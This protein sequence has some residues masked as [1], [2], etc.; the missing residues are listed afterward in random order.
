MIEVIRP[1]DSAQP[2]ARRR[3][4]PPALPDPPW[5]PRLVAAAID[6]LD[7]VCRKAA[8]LE[9]RFAGELC[10][11]HSNFR[12]S[13]R[14]LV[15]YLALRDHDIR[16]LQDRLA[17]LG[18]SSLGRTE[19]HVIASID[20]VARILRQLSGCA[21]T[22]API[23]PLPIAFAAGEALLAAHTAAAL[24]PRRPECGAHI[25]VTMPR[26][27]ADDYELVRQ[28][29]AGGMDCM[30]INCAH[31]DREAWSRMVANLRRAMKEL[32]RDC[33]LLMDLSGPKL[34]TGPIDPTSQT[35][36]WK[37]VRN[38]GG[39]VTTPA[40]VW[41][42]AAENPQR[43]PAPADAYLEVG[44]E[45]LLRA[46]KA[47]RLRFT[48]LR[49]KSRMLELRAHAPGGRWASG[50]KSAYLAEG[51]KLRVRHIRKGR[52]GPRLIEAIPRAPSSDRHSITL[53]PGDRLLVTAAP[54]PGRP[55]EVDA[56]G[57]RLQ[58]ATISCTARARHGRTI[59]GREAARRQG[60]Q[61]A[62]QPPPP[63]GADR[64]G[65][66]RSRL[67]GSPR[68]SGWPLVRAHPGRRP[69]VAPATG[70]T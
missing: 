20:A 69:R 23:V 59:G 37:P 3:R 38:E 19:S 64:E 65:P 49:G 6:E 11:V 31:D 56:R 70:A 24:G 18:L 1:L 29:L 32:R 16:A 7:A 22:A 17:T 53:R 26:E 46:R 35:L 43:P 61:P 51:R 30:R 52:V 27:A 58:P 12:D 5:D 41:L 36:H 47:D 33:R 14:N 4:R 67:R 68:R 25:M 13:A 54:I 28:A 57:R 60:D 15:H 34:R 42:T 40:R 21:E 48:D 55:A 9:R 45:W 62:R 50:A 44:G 66:R 39:E 8:Q 63:A 2:K 10:E